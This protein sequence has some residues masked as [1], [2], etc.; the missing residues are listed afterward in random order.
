MDSFPGFGS[1]VAQH[2]WDVI[3]I[4]Q[5]A[6]IGLGLVA[7]ALAPGADAAP[8]ERWR[9]Y[10]GEKASWAYNAAQLDPSVSRTK[11][12]VAHYATFYTDAD[13]NNG[14][15]YNFIVN[16]VSLDCQ[17]RTVKL[18]TAALFDKSEKAVDMLFGDPAKPGDPVDSSPDVDT[19]TKFLFASACDGKDMPAG[20]VDS[21]DMT[22]TL[23]KLKAV[24][25]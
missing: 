1:P 3:L 19:I 18:Q 6:M 4:M 17:A 10:G 20:A 11:P 21:G 5:H 25:R 22:S 24:T 12:L 7:A 9:V 13:T 15:S 8:N 2:I 16:E 23:S 14:K